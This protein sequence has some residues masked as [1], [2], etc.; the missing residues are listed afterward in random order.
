MLRTLQL[1]PGQLDTEGRQLLR[2]PHPLPLPVK[3]EKGKPDYEE[4][5]QVYLAELQHYWLVEMG[6]RTYVADTL[7]VEHKDVT[8]A[9]RLIAF[10]ARWLQG[11]RQVEWQSNGFVRVLHLGKLK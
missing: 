6:L 2:D 4:L 3:P 7:Y 9:A 1:L 10:D 5:K 11:Q 8:Y